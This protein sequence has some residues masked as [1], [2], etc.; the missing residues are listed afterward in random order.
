M[1]LQLILQSIFVAVLVHQLIRS[2]RTKFS[3]LKTLLPLLPKFS[4][5]EA[6]ELLLS[7]EAS[8]DAKSICTTEMALLAPISAPSKTEHSQAAQSPPNHVNSN[9]NYDSQGRGGGGRNNNN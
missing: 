5:N 7:E 9:N 1:T 4:F 2:L 3:V 8:W 6:C